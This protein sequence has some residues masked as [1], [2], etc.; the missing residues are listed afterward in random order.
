MENIIKVKNVE[1]GKGFVVMA[2]PCA[3]ESLAQLEKT[4]ELI[5]KNTQILR[6]GAYKPRTKPS[7]FQGLKEE[8][9]KLLKQVGDRLNLPTIT[10]IL[11][12]REVALVASFVDIFQVGT[13]N[14]ANYALLKEIGKSGKPVMLKRGMSA[15][16]NE[17]L[18]A[19]EYIFAE[20]NQQVIL[21]E[22][23]IRTFMTETRFTLDLAGAMLAKQKSGLP[24]IIDP[25]H[26]TGIPALIPPMVKAAKAAGFDGIMVE[27]HYDPSQAKCDA[28]Q[29]LT[30]DQ[31]N[32]MFQ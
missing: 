24:V 32:E 5:K 23:G 17:W 6:G 20:G 9:L 19:A 8:G 2:G 14:M 10:E 1:I 16:I 7:S 3:I 30:P 11:D 18:S 27:V 13:R 29:A 25:S 4:A 31:F 15:T 28:E 21:C 26:A 12:P 22:R